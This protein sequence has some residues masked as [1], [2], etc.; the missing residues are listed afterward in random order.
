MQSVGS[1]IVAAWVRDFAPKIRCMVLVSP[2]FKV[3]LYVPLARLGLQLL[4]LLNNPAF[5]KPYVKAKSLTHDSAQVVSYENDPLISRSTSD[6]VLLD[7]DNAGSRLIAVAVTIQ[8]PTQLLIS[9]AGCVVQRKPQ[10]DFFARL[11]ARVKEQHL[12][13]KLDHDTLNEKDGQLP[14][15]EVENLSRGSLPSPHIVHR[16]SIPIGRVTSKASTMP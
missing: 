2:A 1:V 10:E 16:S 15:A 13:A 3:K 7:L 4:L 8:T 6:N 5:V 14:I 9:G 11:G 12:F